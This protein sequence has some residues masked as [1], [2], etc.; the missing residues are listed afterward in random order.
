MGEL[1]TE[2]ARNPPWSRRRIGKEIW[3]EADPKG[4]LVYRTTFNI[5]SHT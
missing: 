2:H 4:D 3:V 1:I 5:K